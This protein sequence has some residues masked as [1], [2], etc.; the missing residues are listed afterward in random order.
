MFIRLAANARWWGPGRGKGTLRRIALGGAAA[1]LAGFTPLSGIQASPLNLF[2]YNMDLTL[3]IP[4]VSD[5]GVD[6][7]GE[8]VNGTVALQ[9]GYYNR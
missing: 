3:V 8:T 7:N 2:P 6:R 4:Y 9:A 1:C 5:G